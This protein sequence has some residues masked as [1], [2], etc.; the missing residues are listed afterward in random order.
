[1]DA[2][3]PVEE[4]EDLD[5]SPTLSPSPSPSEESPDPAR[6]REVAA[7]E[8]SYHGAAG[9]TTVRRQGPDDREVLKKKLKIARQRVRRLE[10]KVSMLNDMV[11]SL[12]NQT[13]MEM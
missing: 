8:H 2:T 11:Y 3:T 4:A 9:A 12:L 5:G 10:E 6:V 1:M 7:L 13:I